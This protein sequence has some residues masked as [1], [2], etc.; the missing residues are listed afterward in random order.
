V[1]KRAGAEVAEKILNSVSQSEKRTT[2]QIS[3]QSGV[4]WESTKRYLELFARL[5][6]ISEVK[7]N[8]RL[9]YLRSAQIE[10]DTFFGIPLKIEHKNQIKRIYAT[11]RYMWPKEKPLSRTIMQKIAVDVV[12]KRFQDIPRGWYLF[13]EILLLPPNTNLEDVSPFSSDSADFD[14]IR[15]SYEKYDPCEDT[16]AVRKRQYEEKRNA[17]YIK[18]E[19]L[20]NMLGQI[21]HISNRDNITQIRKLINEFAVLSEDKNTDSHLIT[22]VEDYCA[23]TLSIFRN[24]D[25]KQI[26][27]AQGSINY[28]FT[29]VWNLIAT[30]EFYNTLSEYY[31]REVL[32]YYFANRFEEVEELAIFALESLRNFEPKFELPKT[33]E[34]EKLLNSAGTARE[35]SDEEKQRREEDAKHLSGSELFGMHGIN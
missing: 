25:L 20:Y 34:T 2:Q 30:F 18:K 21:C 26:R 5:D 9:F 7:E 3:E 10:H 1:V 32:D 4:N 14:A 15:K 16:S 19:E 31:P 6:V 23:S 35:I 29:Q 28:A 12:E 8:E 17:L 22:I 27:D 11:I 24:S 33:S 13:G